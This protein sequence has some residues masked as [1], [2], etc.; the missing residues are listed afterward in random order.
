MA[1]VTAPLFSFSASGTVAGKLTYRAT[2]RGAVCQ[3]RAISGKPANTNQL[4]ERSRFA[5]ALAAWRTLDS[6]T[7]A[8]WHAVGLRFALADHK[9]FTKQYLIQRCTPPQLPRIPAT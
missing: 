8:K 5:D 1:K 7:L 3:T 6:P 9:A 4:R 2:K